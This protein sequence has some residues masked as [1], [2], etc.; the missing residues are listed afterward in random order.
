MSR[1]LWRPIVVAIVLII[2]VIAVVLIVRPQ[3]IIDK[4]RPIIIKIQGYGT[5][6]FE[7]FTDYT[8]SPTAIP[9]QTSIQERPNFYK[10][11][12]ID[13][14]GPHPS[15]LSGDCEIVTTLSKGRISA[16]GG[17]FSPPTVMFTNIPAGAGQT[18]DHCTVSEIYCNCCDPSL[19]K[20]SNITEVTISPRPRTFFQRIRRL[21]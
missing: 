6:P 21:R 13:D 8:L 7:V 12:V 17:P 14:S 3:W 4:E 19:P 2:A 5:K 10:L 11:L 1:K 16:Q 9:G 20:L 18:C 15:Q